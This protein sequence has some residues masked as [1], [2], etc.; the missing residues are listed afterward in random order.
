MAVAIA[1]ANSVSARIVAK[2]GVRLT[3]TLAF[4]ADAVGLLL[5]AFQTSGDSYVLDLLPGL[6]ITGFSHGVTYVAMFIAGTADVE[7]RNQGVAGAMMTTAQYMSGALGVAVLVL[8]LGP[9]PGQT[10]FGWAFVT[11]ATAATF[12]A[13][14]AWFG[15]AR[16][17]AA[18]AV[19]EA[20]GSRS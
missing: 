14:L 19:P 11:T 18:A 10:S 15:L 4:V 2:L 1:V 9:N 13:A 6:L 16:R 5:L 8:V 17:S 3:L 20:S 7:D 12:G